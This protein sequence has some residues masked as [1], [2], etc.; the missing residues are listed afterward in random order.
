MFQITSQNILNFVVRAKI[1]SSQLCYELLQ[2][3]TN[4]DRIDKNYEWCK[5]VYLKNEIDVLNSYGNNNLA[6][7][8]V[9]INIYQYCNVIFVINGVT[10]TYLYTTFAGLA[11]SLTANGYQTTLL[12][13]RN[14]GLTGV[15]NI[16]AQTSAA[17]NGN[18]FSSYQLNSAPP[19]STDILMQTGMF[20]MTPNPCLTDELAGQIVSNICLIT[21]GVSNDQWSDIDGIT[22]LSH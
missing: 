9:E 14:N 4:G 2:K 12:G 8:V 16:C 18:T 6:Y 10:Y 3:M 19:A 5:L 1:A 17:L 13:I 11:A 7:A 15:Y 21:S 20:N 22:Y